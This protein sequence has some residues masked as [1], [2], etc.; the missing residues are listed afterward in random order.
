MKQSIILLKWYM[1]YTVNRLKSR[2]MT[3]FSFEKHRS[4]SRMTVQSIMS[5]GKM[6][7]SFPNGI[8]FVLFQ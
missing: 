1:P 4:M 3:D 7:R 8:S 2:E 6:M 5:V